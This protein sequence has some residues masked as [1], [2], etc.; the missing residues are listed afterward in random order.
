ML[1]KIEIGYIARNIFELL[2]PCYRIKWKILLGATTKLTYFLLSPSCQL[3]FQ[4]SV[5]CNEVL[6]CYAVHQ[7]SSNFCLP[8]L[9]IKKQKVII[10]F[11]PQKKGDFWLPTF[12]YVL[13][14]FLSRHSFNTNFF[15]SCCLLS[16]VLHEYELPGYRNLPSGKFSRHSHLLR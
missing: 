13:S 15:H 3:F 2:L 11:L 5:F 16:C 10:F 12:L 4:P 8:F 14:N 6:S 7:L 9:F 1:Q